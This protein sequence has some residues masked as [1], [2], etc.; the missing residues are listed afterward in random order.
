MLKMTREQYDSIVSHALKNVPNEAC[1]LLGGK[2]AGKDAQVQQVYLLVNAD[3]S[4]E[5]FSMKP[6]EQFAAV[7]AMRK[8]GQQMLG[9]F[10]SHPA[11]PARMSEEDKRLAFDKTIRYLILSLQETEPKLKCFHIDKNAFVTEEKIEV[12]A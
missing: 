2:A 7:K 12:T 3:N 10:H 11:T 8:S 6:A 4:P 1:G 9:N 5:H